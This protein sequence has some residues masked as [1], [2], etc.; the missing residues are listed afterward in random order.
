MG[1]LRMEFGSHQI[2]K[3]CDTLDATCYTVYVTGGTQT[4]SVTDPSGFG[5]IGNCAT[6]INSI[7]LFS[8]GINIYP[9]PSTGKFTIEETKDKIQGTSLEIYNLLGENIYS[10]Q[11]NSDKTEIDLNKQPKGIY[12][13]QLQSDRKILRTG[14]IIID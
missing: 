11:L 7:D 3:R 9:N 8:A 14:K 6:G 4:P 2:R 12:F 1:R 13:Y 5:I 10:S